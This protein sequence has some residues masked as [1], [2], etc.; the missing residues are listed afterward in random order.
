MSKKSKRPG[1]A[2]RKNQANPGTEERGRYQIICPQ[3]GTPVVTT[4]PQDAVDAVMQLGTHFFYE[5]NDKGPFFESPVWVWMIEPDPENE[6]AVI[7]VRHSFEELAALHD[8]AC[9]STH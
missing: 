1:R 6:A 4:N 2:G 9:E 3:T 5:M 8:A 7:A